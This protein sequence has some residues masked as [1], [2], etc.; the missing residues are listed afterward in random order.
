MNESQIKNF[1]LV[2]EEKNFSKAAEKGYM[3]QP[4]LSRSI[5]K[6][7]AELDVQLFERTGKQVQLTEAGK[8]YYDFFRR[9]Q[10]AYREVSFHARKLHSNRL[11]NIR[12]GYMEGWKVS[13]LLYDLIRDFKKEYPNM[14][15]R[16][17]ACNRREL[18]EKLDR[19][20]I[21]LVFGIE[22]ILNQR[23]GIRKEKVTEI[24]RGI[25]CRKDQWCG[26]DNLVPEDF[27]KELFFVMDEDGTMALG[28]QIREFCEPYGFIPQIKYVNSLESAINSVELGQGVLICDEW[29]RYVFDEN[30]LFIPMQTRHTVMLGWKSETQNVAVS[31]LITEIEKRISRD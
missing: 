26:Q 28:T 16:M 6:L 29:T 20:E 1:L 8:E 12:I 2:A 18:L 22:G 27:K 30:L 14:D 17:E 24:V 5:L 4:N 10:L 15:I 21:D 9:T 13:E 31:V 11:G 19:D 3:S 23:R 25:L 7:E